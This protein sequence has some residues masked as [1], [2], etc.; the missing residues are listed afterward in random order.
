MTTPGEARRRKSKPALLDALRC[1]TTCDRPSIWSNLTPL[2]AVD[3]GIMLP[4]PDLLVARWRT[5]ADGGGPP[6]PS[7]IE[8]LVTDG[9]W[10]ES[11]LDE[12]LTRRGWHCAN[13][14]DY[15]TERVLNLSGDE[16]AEKS[17][18]VPCRVCGGGPSTM[19]LCLAVAA[20]GYAT[21]E[22]CEELARAVARWLQHPI[23]RVVW[24]LRADQLP[25]SRTVTFA[26]RSGKPRM[27]RRD[28][29]ITDAFGSCLRDI[30]YDSGYCAPA[31]AL[32]ELG[33]SV[34]RVD[35]GAVY[36]ATE[37]AL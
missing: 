8:L 31:A 36:L 32:W 30:Y 25:E 37:P 9:L 18:E 10:P 23:E 26:T 34:D 1:L 5:A 7:A 11:A 13:C 3:S 4:G 14:D 16:F 35:P 19:P 6:G 21:I 2:R 15:G 20:H 27:I 12:S 17:I 28:G 22:R 33:V 24:R 29:G